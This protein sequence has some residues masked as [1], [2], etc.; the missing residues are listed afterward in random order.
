MK[1][2]PENLHITVH[3]CPIRVLI[4]SGFLVIKVFRSIQLS[5]QSVWLFAG[6][7]GH[8]K[9]NKLKKEKHRKQFADCC[10]IEKVIAY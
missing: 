9:E 3:Q 5:G 6:C 2:V 1:V 8:C 7:S 4:S 10:L